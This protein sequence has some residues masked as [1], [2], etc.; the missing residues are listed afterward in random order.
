MGLERPPSA[1]HIYLDCSQTYNT[2][3]IPYHLWDS[4]YK[5]PA[6]EKKLVS[7]LFHGMRL[8][9]AANY[10][11]ARLTKRQ[12]ETQTEIEIDKEREGQREID[13][14]KRHTESECNCGRR[15]TVAIQF[16]E[17]LFGSTKN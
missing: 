8:K 16:L 11:Q 2:P 3:A 14:R 7:P 17:L 13:I 15:V 12:R 10:K 9:S 1:S 6:K 5:K 4:G